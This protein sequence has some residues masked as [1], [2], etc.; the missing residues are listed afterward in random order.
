[1]ATRTIEIDDARSARLDSLLKQRG[2]TF[3]EFLEPWFA[4]ADAIMRHSPS[5]DIADQQAIAAI[6]AKTAAKAESGRTK[7]LSPKD[8]EAPHNLQPQE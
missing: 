3:E 5:D 4:D 2:C 1:M 7:A 8:K 6:F